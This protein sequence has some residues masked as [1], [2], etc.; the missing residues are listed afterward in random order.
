MTPAQVFVKQADR[1]EWSEE[2]RIGKER[3]VHRLPH[4]VGP[5]DS[6]PGHC[7]SVFI[8]ES[9]GGALAM[10]RLGGTWLPSMLEGSSAIKIA[11]PLE[12][13]CTTAIEVGDGWNNGMLGDGYNQDRRNSVPTR[14]F[15]VEMTVLESTRTGA[16]I[17]VGVLSGSQADPG[18][19]HS[20][21]R[22]DRD[23]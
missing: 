17:G 20:S 6:D 3:L 5:C 7:V 13:E 4:M 16:R 19:I 23:Q 12:V 10:A 8:D 18:S 2:I 21:T 15:T 11:M 9:P 22:C 14:G 1:Y